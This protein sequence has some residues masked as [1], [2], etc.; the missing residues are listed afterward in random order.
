MAA[1]VSGGLHNLG[2]TWTGDGHLPPA[3]SD[4]RKKP[5]HLLIKAEWLFAGFSTLPAGDLCLAMIPLMWSFTR[6][7][8]EKNFPHMVQESWS[9]LNV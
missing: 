5:L 4:L 7:G 9:S 8:M 1:E 2:T 3:A 6:L